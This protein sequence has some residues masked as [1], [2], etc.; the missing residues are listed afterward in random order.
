MSF[1]S[2]PDP[3]A[4]QAAE[5]QAQLQA[6]ASACTN[7]FANLWAPWAWAL[8]AQPWQGMTAHPWCGTARA[9]VAPSPEPKA[10]PAAAA[11]V[12]AKA[13][14]DVVPLTPVAPVV[15][16]AA[17]APAQAVAPV[18]AKPDK[19][20]RIE[21]IGPQIARVLGEAGITTFAGLS[22]TSVDRLESLLAAAG[23]RF[24]LARPQ[25]WP[26][27]AALLAAGDEAGFAAL[28]AELKGGVRA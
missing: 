23:P 18:A 13:V 24:K 22:T 26:E 19:L 25:T 7:L 16:K 3:E 11:P 10:A 12:A 15:A 17:P 4:R 6:L 20:T 8:W 5:A 2:L 1:M 28:T 14:A 27:Q 21:G 9:G